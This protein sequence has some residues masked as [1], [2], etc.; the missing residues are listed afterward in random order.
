MKVPKNFKTRIAGNF[1]EN[2]PNLVVCSGTTIL[3]VQRSE[4]NGDLE[5]TDL[6][7]H[8]VRKE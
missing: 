2:T 5:V 8:S 7:S 3:R 6:A 4:D 1:Y